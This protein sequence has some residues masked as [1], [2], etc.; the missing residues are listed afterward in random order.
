[1]ADPSVSFYVSAHAD[2]WQLFMSPTAVRDL[3][4]AAAGARRVVFV[5]LTA[6]DDGNDRTFWRARE[7]GAVNSVRY[8][9]GLMPDFAPRSSWSICA[10]HPVATYQ[11][12]PTVSYFLRLPDGNMDGS[13]YAVTDGQTLGALVADDLAMT[14]LGDHGQGDRPSTYDGRSDLVRTIAAIVEA[15]RSPHGDSPVR[16]VD[17]DGADPVPEG[18][19]EHA[20]HIATGRVAD[21][22]V[23]MV[24]GAYAQTYLDYDAEHLPPN[25]EGDDLRLKLGMFLAYAMAAYATSGATYPLTAV[26]PQYQAWLRREVPVRDERAR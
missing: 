10:G 17:P 22:V 13:G 11:V 24:E 21:E 14:S 2:D 7:I 12:G 3:A 20:D 16:F 25:V 9:L 6:G 1:M 23:G 8:G 4:A 5:H 19:S 15:E 18:H 26:D